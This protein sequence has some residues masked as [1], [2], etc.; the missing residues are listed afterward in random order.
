MN[1]PNTTLTKRALF[2]I[3]AAC[4]IMDFF[5]VVSVLLPGM[6]DS[7]SHIPKEVVALV[8]S[9]PS[10][11]AVVTGYAMGPILLK[12]NRKT[13]IIVGVGLQ[14][15]SSAIV[16]LAGKSSFAVLIFAAALSGIVFGIIFASANSAIAEYDAP[17]RARKNLGRTYAMFP[18][19]NTVLSYAAGHLA[20]G[21]NWPLGYLPLL[22][23][24]VPILVFAILALPSMP[25][26]YD[27]AINTT[28]DEPQHGVVSGGS[29][30]TLVLILIT[31]FLFVIGG[32]ITLL[33]N[34]AS[35]IIVDHQ[36]GTEAEAGTMALFFS[37]GGF[38]GAFNS[39]VLA[40]PL[41]A[42]TLTVACAI[43]VVI[44]LVI[45]F[46]PNLIVLYVCALVSGLAAGLVNA[47]G[48]SAV[49]ESIRKAPIAIGA[50]S[51]LYSLALFLLPWVSAALNESGSTTYNFWIGVVPLL[52]ASILGIYVMN[53]AEKTKVVRFSGESDASPR[54][55]STLL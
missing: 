19:G 50:Y 16:L 9:V 43:S 11:L 15:I 38:L 46:I 6:Y 40:K 32:P 18:L 52:I 55:P 29:T 7:F 54:E 23:V 25:P 10:L 14:S 13:A 41:R 37:L 39:A 4:L 26:A 42:Y 53:R 35:Y 31:V 22:V 28:A 36:L 48:L 27:R 2:S 5:M 20:V 24:C 1:A 51:T 49:A 30:P 34:F 12:M 45:I 21:G 44:V 8:I 33:L 3:F 47:Y 17:D